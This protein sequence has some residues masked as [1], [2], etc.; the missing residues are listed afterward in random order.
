M[1]L[2][3]RTKCH[4]CG[5]DL[6]NRSVSC[7]LRGPPGSA[8]PSTSLASVS[9]CSNMDGRALTA[10][11][12][13]M[14]SLARFHAWTYRDRLAFPYVPSSSAPEPTATATS[15]QWFSCMLMLVALAPLFVGGETRACGIQQGLEVYEPLASEP[16]EIPPGIGK[17][18][19][20][21][22]RDHRAE[23]ALQIQL[24]SGVGRGPDP[25]RL[26]S[27]VNKLHP[28]G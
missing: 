4:C 15:S 9:K 7:P 18:G 14:H 6:R 20:G 16:D 28:D 27:L 10:R 5:P 3:C 2:L 13:R 11:A 23:R 8:S 22:L 1:F 26:R 25:E 12:C 19:I 24:R 17:L 21:P